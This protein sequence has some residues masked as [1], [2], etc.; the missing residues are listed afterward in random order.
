MISNLLWITCDFVE[1][2]FCFLGDDD[3]EGDKADGGTSGVT[4]GDG[5]FQFALAV[6]VIFNIQVPL[7]KLWLC[8]WRC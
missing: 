6:L 1:N 2:L 4:K 5:E 8:R 7:W 3:V